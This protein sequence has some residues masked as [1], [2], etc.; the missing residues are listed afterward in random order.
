MIENERPFHWQQLPLL[1][2]RPCDPGHAGNLKHVHVAA[3]MRVRI[4]ALCHV[5]FLTTVFVQNSGSSFLKVTSINLLNFFLFLSLCNFRLMFMNK[6]VS[7]FKLCRILGSLI[8]LNKTVGCL[9][10]NLINAPLIYLLLLHTDA[11]LNNTLIEILISN[12]GQRDPT[13]FLSLY[14]PG[15]VNRLVSSFLN[16]R[17]NLCYTWMAGRPSP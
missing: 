5:S 14:S 12:P 11:I 17:S 7:V 3:A 10:S 13:I 1:E 6:F 2:R 9:C 4:M 16:L 15:R 8:H